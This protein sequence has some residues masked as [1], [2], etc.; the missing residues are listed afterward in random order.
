MAWTRPRDQYGRAYFANNEVPPADEAFA[1]WRNMLTHPDAVHTPQAKD[2]DRLCV[3]GWI[4]S[5]EWW[6]HCGRCRADR[7]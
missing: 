5:G 1:H 3:G 4:P 7:S 6:H 2:H